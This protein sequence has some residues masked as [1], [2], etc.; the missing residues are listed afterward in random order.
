M[1]EK[2][3]FQA[4]PTTSTDEPSDSFEED[5][6]TMP[7]PRLDLSLLPTTLSSALRSLPHD[8]VRPTIISLK[9]DW[10]RTRAKSILHPPITTTLDED[11]QKIERNAAFDLLDALSRSGELVLENVHLHVVSAATHAFDRTLVE[12]V[13]RGNVD[14]LSRVS[15]TSMIVAG[16]VAGIEEEQRGSLLRRPRERLAAG[17]EPAAR[18]RV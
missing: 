17:M 16:V 11:T 3:A 9:D 13:I 14:P 12:T 1:E 15:E 5:D 4:F 18:I 8:A 2:R 6:H 7:D 10:K